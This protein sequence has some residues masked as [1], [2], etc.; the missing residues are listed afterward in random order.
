MRSAEDDPFVG[1]TALVTG[2]SSGIG[3]EFARHLATKAASLILVARRKDRLMA[4]AEELQSI[5][6]Q[7]TIWT[8]TVDLSDS[9]ELDRFLEKVNVRGISVDLLVNNAGLGDMGPF[10]TASW[11]KVEQMLRVNILAATR[12]AWEVI[13]GMMKKKR[14]WI[15][16]VGSIAGFHPIPFFAV[17][18]AS[19]AY[20]NSFSESLYWEL[21]PYGITVTAVCPGPVATE[22]FD[23]ACRR[24]EDGGV[25][26]APDFMWTTVHEVVEAAL[27]AARQGRPRVVPGMLPGIAA[28]F[29][30]ALPLAIWRMALRWKVPPERLRFEGSMGE[31]ESGRTNG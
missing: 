16:N 8:E 29:Y 2:A 9:A 1:V 27:R 5:S 13:P 28:S 19:K 11:K 17:Y 4:L 7:L 30:A 23:R 6:G 21:S 22:F 12:I 20:L 14:G 15:I 10:H 18:A 26:L 24:K 31:G 25:S 3:R